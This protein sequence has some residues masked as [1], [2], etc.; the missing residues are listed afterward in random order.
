MNRHI[1]L[2]HPIFGFSTIRKDADADIRVHVQVLQHASDR[3]F[4]RA[5]CDYRRPDWLAELFFAAVFGNRQH[6]AELEHEIC[7]V[8][9]R[10]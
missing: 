2:I 9:E 3:L 8:A 1:R 7:D 10:R 4:Y 5:G 6:G